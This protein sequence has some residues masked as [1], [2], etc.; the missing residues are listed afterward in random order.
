[1]NKMNFI[2]LVAI[3]S[4]FF[5][6]GCQRAADTSS[7][8]SLSVP[9]SLTFQ[10][11]TNL[12]KVGASS[13]PTGLLMHVA[14]N[15][16]ASDIPVPISYSFDSDKDAANPQA[17]PSQFTIED[18]PAGS[19]RMIQVLAVYVDSSSKI[20]EF[21]YGDVTTALASGDNNIQISLK[22]SGSGNVNGSSVA[23]RYFDSDGSTPTGVVEARIQPAGDKPPMIIE[24]GWMVNG[25]FHSFLLTNVPLDIVLTPQ[26][27][28]LF[29]STQANAMTFADNK[30]FKINIPEYYRDWG[31]STRSFNRPESVVM[32]F[33][34]PGVPAGRSVCYDSTAYTFSTM[35]NASTGGSPISW[36]ASA[37][38]ADQIT[39]T[40][41]ASAV[42]CS[43]NAISGAYLTDLIF[44][45]SRV[46]MNGSKEAIFGFSGVFTYPLN[47]T[48]SGS[49]ID[50]NLFGGNI[51]FGYKLL[52]LIAGTHIDAVNVYWRNYKGVRDYESGQSVACA[53]IMNGGYGFSKLTSMPMTAGMRDYQQTVPAPSGID[54]G[55]IA[56]CPIKNG[57]SMGGGYATEH[58]SATAPL[59]TANRVKATTVNNKIGYGQCVPVDIELS[60]SAGLNV[61]TTSDQTISLGS[62]AGSFY[63]SLQNCQAASPAVTAAVI[64]A[65]TLKSSLWY[66][67]PASTS[68]ADT[69]SISGSGL[70]VQNTVAF[71]ISTALTASQIHLVTPSISL[72]ASSCAS[73]QGYF[74][75]VNGR[76]S[77]P[78]GSLSLQKYSDTSTAISDANFDFYANCAA[79][80]ISSDLAVNTPNFSFAVKT[81]PTTP[82]NRLIKLMNGALYNFVYMNTVP[83]AVNLNLN[84]NSN[85]ALWV[86]SCAP[87][88]VTAIDA[89]GATQA[90]ATFSYN[91]NIYDTAASG[92]SYASLFSDSMCTGTTVSNPSLAAGVSSLFI[93]A[94]NPGSTVKMM[95]SSPSL[96]APLEQ[97]LVIYDVPMRTR[98]TSNKVHFTSD[99][100]MP[101]SNLGS[102][103]HWQTPKWGLSGA[104][105]FIN[106]T[107]GSD[108][109]SQGV[110][111]TSNS[112]MSF[113]ISGQISGSDELAATVKFKLSALSPAEVL[114]VKNDKTS[115]YFDVASGAGYTCGIV[116]SVGTTSGQLKC[117]GNYTNGK[118]GLGSIASD[119]SVPSDVVSLNNTS[120][121]ATGVNHT[122]AIHNSQLYCFGANDYAQLGNGV[123]S[124]SPTLTPQTLGAAGEFS[125]IKVGS[126]HSCALRTDST[127]AC[128]GDNVYK[129]SQPGSAATTI[130]TPTQVPSLTNITSLSLGSNH[131]CAVSASGIVSCWG[132]NTNGELGYSGA[133]ASTPTA[134]SGNYLKVSAGFTHT[135]AIG[136]TGGLVYCWG[137]N[138]YGQLGNNTTTSSPTPVTVSTISNAI[139]ISSGANHTCAI[140]TSND[141]YCWGNSALGQLA[142][143]PSGN[144]LTPQK[145]APFGA[146]YKVSA[147]WD[148]TCAVG[149]NSKNYCWGTNAT[150]QLGDGSTLQR[151]IPTSIDNYDLSLGI[152]STASG[153]F[154]KNSAGLIH[155]TALT[156]NTNYTVTLLRSGANIRTFVNGVESAV[157]SGQALDPGLFNS[158]KIGGNLTGV[159]KALQLESSPSGI[160]SSFPA[161]GE[162]TYLNLRVP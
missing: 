1:M 3:T 154:L 4:M 5:S 48:N 90:S 21:Y 99:T 55:T 19:D 132:N 71:D 123:S 116:G 118:L 14:I 60:S 6:L 47:S 112:S 105:G 80:T 39:V 121:V 139:E 34:G 72:P 159:F 58:F 134:V 38:G 107:T 83:L 77:F 97:S 44:S 96:G 50:V 51:T 124:P 20:G 149:K 153:F 150:Y 40:K 15:V 88:S 53:K 119:Q 155:P 52:P 56:F 32:G 120:V 115:Y 65:G 143:T 85:R 138:T 37:S 93:L 148:H 16:R 24:R 131:S 142:I 92:I 127:V 69:I 2:P 122:C 10:D 81:G 67:S 7:R 117:W 18:L 75:D 109:A 70:T 130:S 100:A 36:A 136:S 25:W 63:T 76:L 157:A 12:Q 98:G 133:S 104:P 87:F 86:G 145:I 29:A 137:N 160:Y 26:N 152:I 129:Q 128:W 158:V 140:T 43:A 49:P 57:V 101:S 78:S 28:T 11:K 151:N 41:A 73:L 9:Q 114:T 110:P 111:F 61:T 54:N 64:S 95:P 103:Y 135:C 147:G 94:N 144:I 68:L 79:G 125:D 89:S 42:S 113:Y 13:V 35:Y 62:S 22:L 162:N 106:L 66:R 108:P 23:G 102:S 126:L 30:S 46:N 146:W 27:L 33:F 31:A 17:L 161:S 74:A 8:L 156:A 84:A 91:I 59:V 141:L 82:S 45:P